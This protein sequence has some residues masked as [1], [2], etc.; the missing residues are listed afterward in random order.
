MSDDLSPVDALPY[1][2]EA[3]LRRKLIFKE[4]KLIR[5]Y[6]DEAVGTSYSRGQAALR[7]F[8]GLRPEEL[9]ERAENWQDTQQLSQ[10]TLKWM[11]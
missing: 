9:K 3:V 1:A 7:R 2:A 4:V 11:V 8:T 10:Q 5:Q 6:Y